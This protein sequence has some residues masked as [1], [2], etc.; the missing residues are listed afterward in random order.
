MTEPGPQKIAII[1]GNGGLPRILAAECAR[2]GQLCAVVVFAARAPDWAASY[3]V[4]H[5][6]FEQLGALFGSLEKAGCQ[7]V[8]FAGGLV[9]PHFDPGKFDAK[10]L[11]IAPRLLP[12]IGRGDDVTLAAVTRIFEDEG[13]GVVAAQDILGHL[14]AREGALGQISSSSAALAEIRRAAR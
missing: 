7:N 13:L 6:A 8:I 4:I 5:A 2:R 1:A 14:L 11:E 12:F 9:R 3:P 10:T